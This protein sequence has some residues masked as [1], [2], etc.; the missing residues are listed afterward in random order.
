MAIWT[1]KHLAIRTF[2]QLSLCA[3]FYYNSLNEGYMSQFQVLLCGHHSG[4][5]TWGSAVEWVSVCTRRSGQPN[6]II[7]LSIDYC[8]WTQH[9]MTQPESAVLHSVVRQSPP[10]IF[11]WFFMSKKWVIPKHSWNTK[12]CTL[13]RKKIIM[14]LH[15]RGWILNEFEINCYFSGNKVSW[16][17]GQK[18]QMSSLNM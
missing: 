13:Q 17:S 7:S 6:N 3:I 2:Q 4:D 8:W 1:F 18:F 15:G 16:K 11:I 14:S 12:L 9:S 5:M 10:P